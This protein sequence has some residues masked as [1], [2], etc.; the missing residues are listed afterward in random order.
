MEDFGMIK[1]SCNFFLFF[2]IQWCYFA[3]HHI[4]IFHAKNPKKTNVQG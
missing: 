2:G 3:H 4:K 1:F